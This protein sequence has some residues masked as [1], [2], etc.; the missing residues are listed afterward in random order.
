MEPLPSAFPEL[1]RAVKMA[2]QGNPLVSK[3]KFPG[4]ACYFWKRESPLPLF[5]TWQVLIF[6][7]STSLHILSTV[8]TAL[9][10]LYTRHDLFILSQFPFSVLQ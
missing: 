4:D 5:E 3:Y 9:P 10:T 7:E 6:K 2:Q 1:E 8:S